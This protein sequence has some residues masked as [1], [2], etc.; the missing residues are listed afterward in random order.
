[1]DSEAFLEEG[2]KAFQMALGGMSKLKTTNDEPFETEM[3]GVF[4][5]SDVRKKN[6]IPPQSGDCRYDFDTLDEEM[7]RNVEASDFW[8][9]CNDNLPDKRSWGKKLKKEQILSFSKSMSGTIFRLN[10]EI[11]ELAEKNFKRLTFIITESLTKAQVIDLT[12]KMIK[13]GMKNTAEFRD[14]QYFQCIKQ[15][16]HNT[17]TDSTYAAWTILA[18]L[19]CYFSPSASAVHPILNYMKYFAL[20]HP[21][22][23]IQVWAKFTFTRIIDSFLKGEPRT[24]LPSNFELEYI[25]DHRKIPFTI[26][27]CT[28]GT[29]EVFVENYQTVGDLKDKVMEKLGLDMSKRACYGF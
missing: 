19:A 15:L 22:D 12:K 8:T 4:A 18:S 24:V 14:E 25:R 3:D 28:G 20:N 9:F 23:E 1:M 2:F 26:S 17:H 11:K 13:A 10:D 16:R 21:D 5:P 6:Q 27:F 29:M 7:A